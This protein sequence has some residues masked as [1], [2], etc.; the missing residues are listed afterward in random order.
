MFV[1]FAALIISVYFVFSWSFSYWVLN[2]PVALFD[3]EM[4]IDFFIEHYIFVVDCGIAK[5]NRVGWHVDNNIARNIKP[6]VL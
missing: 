3:T 4:C 2:T 1:C 6:K 5:S